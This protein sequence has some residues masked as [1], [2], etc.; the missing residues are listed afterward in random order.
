MYRGKTNEDPR[1]VEACMETKGQILTYQGM[2]VAAYFHADSAGMTESVRFVWG[3][4]IPYLAAVEEIPHESHHSQWEVA[5]DLEI[6]NQKP[7]E[8]ARLPY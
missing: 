2:P 7:A 8:Y 6:L 1:A 5:F 4:D 3:G